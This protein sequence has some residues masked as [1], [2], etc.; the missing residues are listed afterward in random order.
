MD[1]SHHVTVPL[2]YG[3]KKMR[4]RRDLDALLSQSHNKN[5]GNGSGGGGGGC[6]GGG[7]LRRC[8]NSRGAVYSQD[9][10]LNNAST[11]DQ[12]DYTWVSPIF[13]LIIKATFV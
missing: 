13:E 5:G 6:G 2:R 9:K 10:L 11:D 3:I 7:A 12:E 8:N 1:S 4:K